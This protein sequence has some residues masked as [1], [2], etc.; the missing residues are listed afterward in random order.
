MDMKELEKSLILG[1]FSVALPGFKEHAKQGNALAQN[2]IG[3]M[4][5]H[6]Y[7]VKVDMAKAVKW[8]KKAAKKGQ[9]DAMYNL[10]RYYESKK[11]LLSS[12]LWYSL[13]E[14][15]YKKPLVRKSAKSS[16]DWIGKKLFDKDVVESYELKNNILTIQLA[17]PKQE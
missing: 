1:E 6:G 13:A 11:D 2:N 3:I 9:P 8:F 14:K 15:T 4:Y 5:E 7:G 10:G 12:Y 17:L 16:R